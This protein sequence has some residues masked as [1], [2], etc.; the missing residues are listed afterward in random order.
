M[1]SIELNTGVTADAT[2]GEA[3]GTIIVDDLTEPFLADLSYWTRTQ[4]LRSWITALTVLD[5]TEVATTCLITS[6]SDPRTANF[7]T[8]WPLYRI[9]NEVHVQNQVIFLDQLEQKFD[10]SAP[11]RSVASRE[12]VNE[13]GV[14]L[15]E[16]HCSIYEIRDCASRLEKLIN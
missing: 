3:T 16:W 2:G 7:I 13:D 14:A 15:S 11:W 9:G 4:Y 12:T 5:S 8:S 10:E 1:F 6:M